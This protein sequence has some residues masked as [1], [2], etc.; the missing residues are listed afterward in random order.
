MKGKIVLC[1]LMLTSFV[2]SSHASLT[3][4]NAD[5]EDLPNTN[6]NN[7]N[8]WT[9]T[10]NQSGA[11]YAEDW[12]AGA[13]YGVTLNLQ[14]RGDGN[15]VEQSFLTS[16]VTADTYS[17]IEVTMDLGTRGNTGLARTLDVEIWNVTDGT[18]LASETY[19]FPTAGTGFLERKT[20][21]L[22]YDNTLA[23]LAGDEI[24]LKITSNGEGNT[25][26]TTHWIDNVVAVPEPGSL[27]MIAVF[28]AGLLFIR[29][30]RRM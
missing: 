14:A 10:E 22:S 28:G 9:T 23:G 5:F 12:G 24:S 4:V 21:S 25:W 1:A 30:Y 8:G 16:E 27:S 18:S 7:P 13:G 29:H 6:G 11:F 17:T 3:L 15:I 19:A 2:V 20:F 26:K